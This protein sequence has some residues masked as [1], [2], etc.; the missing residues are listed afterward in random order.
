MKNA[1]TGANAVDLVRPDAM[2]VPVAPVAPVAR[3]DLVRRA[4]SA[5]VL[6]A[7]DLAAPG[8]KVAVANSAAR[9]AIS[10]VAKNANAARRL[11]H[12]RK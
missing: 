2:A 1:V 11:R 4:A 10:T 9:A 7:L 12:C 8:P 6:V 5:V 3:A